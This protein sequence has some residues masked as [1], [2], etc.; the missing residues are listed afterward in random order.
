MITAKPTNV[1]KRPYI[2][3]CYHGLS[4]EMDK[5]SDVRFYT[6]FSLLLCPFYLSTF[7]EHV[8][9]TASILMYCRAYRLVDITNAAPFHGLFI[10]VAHL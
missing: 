5:N 6:T 7:Q 9:V 10:A 3:I 2:V 8:I 1:D 4:V